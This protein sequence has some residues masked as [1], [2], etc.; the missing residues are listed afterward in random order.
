M[1]E[2]KKGECRKCGII[3]YI[4]DHHIFSQAIFG[5]GETTS[6]CPNC[7]THFHEYQKMN[8]KDPE[9]KKEAFNIW[10]TWFKKISVVVTLSTIIFFAA[11]YFN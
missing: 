7:H 3:F 1:K 2:T 11:Q 9:N 6:L 5:K 4:H 8:T 10:D